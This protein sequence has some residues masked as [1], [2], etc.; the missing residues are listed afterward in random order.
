MFL[1]DKVIENNV[2]ELDNVSLESS[3]DSIKITLLD[4]EYEYLALVAQ[5]TIIW[6]PPYPNNSIAISNMDS[7]LLNDFYIQNWGIIALGD[8]IGSRGVQISKLIRMK[9]LKCW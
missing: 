1:T 6:G 2:N 9:N 8:S 3:E 4:P 5:D 7:T